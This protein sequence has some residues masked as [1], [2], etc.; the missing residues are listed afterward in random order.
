M[1]KTESYKLNL[2]VLSSII[3]LAIA[4]IISFL[5][6]DSS[7]SSKIYDPHKTYDE[8]P[9]VFLIKSLGKTYVPLWLIFIWGFFSKRIEIILYAAIALV[10]T[11]V[12]VGPSKVIFERQRPNIY[13]GNLSKVQNGKQTNESEQKSSHK[14]KADNQS[15]PSGDTATIF[16]MVIVVSPFLPPLS[17]AFLICVAFAVGAMR[18]IGVVH[19]PSDVLAGAVIGIICGR[20]GI[21]L[22][23]KWL[24]KNPFPFGQQW[25]IIALIGVL[26]I[27]A[28]ALISKGLQNLFL[29]LLSAAAL[30]ALFYVTLIIQRILINNKK[31]AAADN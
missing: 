10:L 5:F 24:Q 6:F 25:R 30:A 18:V 3:I 12:I 9:G 31:V 29:F 23:D 1:L 22:C 2:F 28:L 15:F 4:A 27:P 20:A 16:A 8:F 14:H 13:F 21:W 17:F 26:L 7:I 19:Y 11:F